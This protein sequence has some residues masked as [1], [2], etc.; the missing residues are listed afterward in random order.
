[1][2]HFS[3]HLFYFICL[4]CS[5][6]WL[7][8]YSAQVLILVVIPFLQQILNSI[9]VYT[10]R[11]LFNLEY[12]IR[13]SNS[14]MSLDSYNLYYSKYGNISMIQFVSL[15]H[16]SSHHIS[17]T[18]LDKLGGKNTQDR[19]TPA[20]DLCNNEPAIPGNFREVHCGIYSLIISEWLS[21]MTLFQ[22]FT[23][24][25]L[26]KLSVPRDGRLSTVRFIFHHT[27]HLILVS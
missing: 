26:M 21:D 6:I 13:Y 5:K 2:I 19:D 9:S 1:M 22:Y 4:Q 20:Y 8:P 14:F 12:K 25:S 18:P 11:N 17:Q 27:S 16:P 10:S 23:L 24:N 3:G 15:G 7:T